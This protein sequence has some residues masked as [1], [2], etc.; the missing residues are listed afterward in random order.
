MKKPPGRN[1]VPLEAPLSKPS[2]GAFM[3][4]SGRLGLCGKFTRILKCYGIEGR[5]DL[6]GRDV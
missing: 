6:L 1:I 3:A 5:I 2:G 4:I